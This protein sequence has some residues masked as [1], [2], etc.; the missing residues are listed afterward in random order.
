V[1]EEAS[2]SETLVNLLHEKSKII[3]FP[4]MKRRAKML[5]CLLLVLLAVHDFGAASSNEWLN[6]GTYYIPS[7][8]MTNIN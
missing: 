1:H 8:S 3:F 2:L 5:S 4:K 6:D 7:I